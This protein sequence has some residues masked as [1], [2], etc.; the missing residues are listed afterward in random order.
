[1]PPAQPMNNSPSSSESRF[2]RYLPVSIPSPSP[3]APVSPVSSSTVKSASSGPC[4]AAGSSS[5][6]NAAAMP[7]PQSAP[8]VVPSAF[9]HPPSM[10]VRMASRSKSN[11]T[12]ERFSQTMSMCDCRITPGR[13]S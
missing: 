10:R 4:C 2:R 5:T 3:K 7:M 1:M 12:S 8:S 13:S 6:A 9:T 11:T